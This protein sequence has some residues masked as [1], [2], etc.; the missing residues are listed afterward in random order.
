MVLAVTEFLIC[1]LK[2]LLSPPDILMLP[3][4][5]FFGITGVTEVVVKIILQSKSLLVLTIRSKVL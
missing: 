2:T 4:H 3:L 1:T 5:L